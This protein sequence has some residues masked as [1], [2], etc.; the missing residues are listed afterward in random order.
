MLTRAER[1][2][3]GR[4]YHGDIL[5]IEDDQREGGKRE[6]ESETERERERA[7]EIDI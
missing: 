4:N 3:V 5:E 6:R 7:R 1:D 2:D